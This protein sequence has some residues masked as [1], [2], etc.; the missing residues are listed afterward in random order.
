M[1]RWQPYAYLDFGAAGA[2]V[3]GMV[4]GDLIF[5][6]R[7]VEHDTGTE[8]SPSFKTAIQNRELCETIFRGGLSE[9]GVRMGCIA[10]GDVDVESQEQRTGLAEMHDALAACWES[11]AIARVCAKHR[12]PFFSIRVISDIGDGDLR[13]E[14]HRNAERVLAVAARKLVELVF[15]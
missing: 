12:V 8:T 9:L 14:Y 10:A 6:D 3:P 4:A 13:D 1:E 2:L 11:S 15:P 7:V 5:A